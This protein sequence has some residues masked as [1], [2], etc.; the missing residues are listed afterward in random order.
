MSSL[1]EE[2]TASHEPS[3]HH[4]QPDTDGG[5]G[6]GAQEQRAATSEKS[7]AESLGNPEPSHVGNPEPMAEPKAEPK[8]EQASIA[9]SEGTHAEPDSADSEEA[10]LVKEQ[11]TTEDS[12]D[13]NVAE[14]VVSAQP[15][16]EAEEKEMNWPPS[17]LPVPATAPG[18]EPPV[19][20]VPT[21]SISHIHMCVWVYLCV[22]V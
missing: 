11:P 16:P 6:D 20:F 9:E 14:A 5:T 12:T 22:C 13:E 2:P 7:N 8:A 10:P 21:H 18:G 1:Q 3:A 15:V 4:P 19:S 17:A